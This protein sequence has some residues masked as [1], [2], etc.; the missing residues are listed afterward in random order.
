V[1]VKEMN[2]A[3]GHVKQF[4]NDK[5]SVLGLNKLLLPPTFTRHIAWGLPDYS[6]RL[7]QGDKIVYTTE[8]EHDGQITCCA[9]T[10][11]GRICVSGAVDSV[12]CVYK[13]I[14]GKQFVA[15]KRLC[16]HTA[17]ISCVAASRPHSIIVSGSEDHT[18][19]IWDLNR[20]TY[21]RQL[22]FG[23]S[24]GKGS[25][26]C[27]AVHDVTG[28]IVTCC[29]SFISIWSI[30]G[31]LL[32]SSEAQKNV[33]DVISVCVWSKAPEWLYENVLI[34]G[35]RD[36]K[37]KVWVLETN[38]DKDLET[39]PAKDTKGHQNQNALVELTQLTNGL[40]T[41]P[42]TTLCLSAD[43]QRLFSGDNTG[44]VVLWAET[45]LSAKSKTAWA[46]AAFD[47]VNASVTASDFLSI[48]KTAA[49]AG[50]ET[51]KDLSQQDKS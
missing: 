34:S 19:I 37:I 30:N 3:V 23:Q 42:I 51:I 47:F 40:H 1:V 25:I 20:L 18:C 43:S 13:I 24:S 16:G 39:T 4:A 49:I 10:E 38:K 46:H 44:K 5:I 8:N 9:V 50:R 17:L 41:T 14:K 27:V 21:V 12:V 15:A 45:D 31:D 35:H 32:V 22:T 33:N 36:G 28:N 7:M 11:D 26:S 6:L 48:V 29:G 2:E